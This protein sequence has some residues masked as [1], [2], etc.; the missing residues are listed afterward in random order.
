MVLELEHELEKPERID[1]QLAYRRIRVDRLWLAAELL[2]GKLGERGEC[3]RQG[4]SEREGSSRQG[5]VPVEGVVNTGDDRSIDS[6][7]TSGMPN[8]SKKTCFKV[9]NLYQLKEPSVEGFQG[10]ICADDPDQPAAANG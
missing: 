2:G 8:G 6:A 1:S 4:A 10:V 5:Q 9:S 3:G 7:V